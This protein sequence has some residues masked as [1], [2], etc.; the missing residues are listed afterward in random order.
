[1]HPQASQV[2]ADLPPSSYTRGVVPAPLHELSPPRLTA[3][4]AAALEAWG[5]AMPGFDGDEA[6]LHGVETRTSAPVA[7]SQPC[8]GCWSSGTA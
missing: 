2:S 7:E 5:A 6:V 8:G 4:L 1:M 3:A